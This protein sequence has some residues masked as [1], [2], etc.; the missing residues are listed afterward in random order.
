MEELP[1]QESVPMPIYKKGDKTDCNNYQD[2]SLLSTS[3]KIVSNIHLSRLSPYVD[4]I[5]GDHQCGYQLYIRFLFFTFF[6]YQSKNESTMRLWSM[7]MILIYW[8]GD[9]T[10]TIR[11]K[12]NAL[13]DASK[14]T[15]LQVNT[16]N[17]KYMLMSHH[18]NVGSK[19]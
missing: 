11:K 13:T 5:I 8:G 12:I 4:E 14:E 3:Y 10:N 6:R 16:E 19:S 17:T 2:I 9:N 15:G 18:Q 7:L 1:Q